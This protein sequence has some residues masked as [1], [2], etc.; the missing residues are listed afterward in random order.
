MYKPISEDRYIHDEGLLMQYLYQCH[1]NATDPVVNFHLEGPCATHNGLYRLLDKFCSATNCD[2]GRISL[3]TGNM[4]ESHPKYN[5][6]KLPKYW[7]EV[8]QIQQWLDTHQ[9]ETGTAP[10]YHFGHFVGRSTWA[11]LWIATLLDCYHSTQT[12]QTFNSSPGSH[13]V[14]KEHIVDRLGLDDLVLHECDILADTVKFLNLCPRTMAKDIEEISRM[15]TFIP[16]T[17]H[18]P[19]QHPA[20]LNILRH[21][22]NIFVDIVCETRVEGNCFFVTEKTWRSIVARRP[23]IVMGSWHFLANLKRLGFQTFD[24]WWDEGYDDC[25]SKNRVKEIEKLLALIAS[26]SL[27]ELQ[28]K[29][30]EMKSVLDHNYTVFQTLTYKQ[31]ADTF[32]EK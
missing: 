8:I 25:E 15:Q 12:L 28:A 21:Y 19:I 29:L 4:I 16:Q 13:Y 31:I 27:T 11:R 26:W 7:Y 6:K 10:A 18:Y 32:D 9:I 20:N 5:V 3:V 17:D 14:V 22:H 1:Q 24:R 23:F 2:P 30:Q